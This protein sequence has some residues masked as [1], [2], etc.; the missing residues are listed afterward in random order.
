M[1]K[2][3]IIAFAA[4]V[5]MNVSAQMN[6]WENGGL[7]AQYAVENV[8][9]VTFGITSATPESGTGKDGITP[10]LKIE[11]DYWFISYDEGVT[12]QQEG[13]AKGEKGEQ[14]I[15]GEVGPRG[16]KGDKGD[17]MFQA[18]TQDSNFVYLTL[19][20]STIVKLVKA[21]ETSNN[22]QPNSDF[23][24]TITYDPNGGEGVMEVDTFYYGITKKMSTCKFT[25]K[26][27]HFVGWN[28]QT[29]GTGAAYADKC[30]FSLNKNI[31]LYA[32]WEEYEAV[33]L[34][35]SVLWATFNIGATTP[36]EVGEK[37]PWGYVQQAS[38]SD[39]SDYMLCNGKLS[40]L[41]K[42]CTVGAYG[43]IDNKTIL[44]VED[45]A[46]HVHWGGEWRMP[47]KEEIDELL[48]KCKWEYGSMDGTSGVKVSGNGNSIFFVYTDRTYGTGEYWSSSLRENL[49]YYSSGLYFKSGYISDKSSIDRYRYFAYCIRPVKDKK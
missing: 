8:D 4:I 10:L 1:K 16:E 14:G 40:S 27:H 39:W 33:D 41:T 48:T 23:I 11:N 13:K 31:T 5:A 25:R 24:F 30:Q 6:V 37:F 35:L 9:S 44:E 46:A 12:W 3:F 15:Q 36:S 17:S 45:D 26:G 49:P 19:L 34:G 43:T 22:D 2:L 28:S 7:A 47:T 21:K 20:D 29:N 42:Y 32:Q 18:V 38:C